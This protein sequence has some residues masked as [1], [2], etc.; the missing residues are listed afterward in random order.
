MFPFTLYVRSYAPFRTFGMGFEGDG[1]KGP[2]LALWG[3]SKRPMT[4]LC[5]YLPL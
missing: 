1:R 2:A 4:S 5:T 3:D